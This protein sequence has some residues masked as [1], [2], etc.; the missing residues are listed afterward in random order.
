MAVLCDFEIKKLVD[1]GTIGLSDFHDDCVQPASYDLRVGKFAYVS[2]QKQPTAMTEGG[3]ILLDP[4][5]FMLITTYERLTLPKN[6][7]GKVGLRSRHSLAG[8]VNLSGP[9]IDP[10]FS[11]HLT[12]GIV[13]MGPRRR[14]IQFKE[15]FFTVE[16]DRL[17]Q[18]PER[19]YSGTFQRTEHI[20]PALIDAVTD[21]ESR[22]IPDMTRR[23]AKA[24]RE[25]ALHRWGLT[26]VG[27]PIAL[28][29]VTQIVQNYFN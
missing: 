11:G 26:V 6:V 5:N 2:S 23:L 22:S 9:Q 16:F 29:V 12:L 8:L 13:N 21:D 17:E 27:I 25:I 18:T 7:R 14:V 4:G 28:A 3:S 19:Q 15:R 10:G 1:E 24:E 20:A